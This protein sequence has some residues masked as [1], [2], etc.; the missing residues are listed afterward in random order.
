MVKSNNAVARSIA[1]CMAL[2]AALVLVSPPAKADV[3]LVEKD[4]WTVY[5]NGRMQAF[6]NYNQGEGYPRPEPDPTGGGVSLLGGGQGRGDASIALEEGDDP[7]TER[8]EVQELR[9]RTGFVGNVIGFGIKNQLT[10][11]TELIGYTAATTTIMS[12]ARRKYT[13]VYPDWRESY[14]RL[15]GGWGQVT[16]GRTLVLFNRGATEITFLYGYKYGLGWPG[17]V[18]S[19]SSAGPGAGHVG[20]GILGNGFG[21]GISYATP[22]MSG[23][24]L[25]VG[26]YDANNI[27]GQ[28]ALERTKWPRVEGEAT[29]EMELGSLG[30][31]KLFGNGAY[32]K[33]Y[34]RE[35]H[36]EQT[37]VGAG[38]GGRFEI[39]PVNLGLA[40][41]MGT[42][43]GIDFALQPHESARKDLLAPDVPFRDVDGFSA[44]L[45]VNLGD[46]FDWMAAAGITRVHLL[47]EDQADWRDDD[48]YDGDGLN[49]D[50]GAPENPDWNDD[51]PCPDDTGRDLCAEYADSTGGVPIKHQ[52]GLSTGLTYHVSENFHAQL[53]YFRA[54]FEWHPPVPAQPGRKGETQNFDVINLGVTYDF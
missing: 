46:K 16:A 30:M 47:E 4:G 39:G 24:K 33:L 54:M 52:I 31:F 15:K 53:E 40:G 18:S 34:A 10:E 43:I 37:V 32:Q 42:G 6:L 26:L 21:A 45:Q 49:D 51:G 20:F 5:I 35:G 38:Y 44:H 25:E 9:I 8:G 29:Y 27:P 23:F 19:L 13:A 2:G 50:T 28:V 41:H 17:T 7:Q 36:Q 3:T 11:G 12:T 48:D 22:D 14:L 1:V